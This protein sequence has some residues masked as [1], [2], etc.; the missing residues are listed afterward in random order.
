MIKGKKIIDGVTGYIVHTIEGTA[1]RIVDILNDPEHAAV[2]AKNGFEHVRSNFLLTR[3]LKDYLLLMIA[4]ERNNG[5]V[6]E[7]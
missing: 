5:D 6:V 3:H 2:M 7:L 4:L 1:K